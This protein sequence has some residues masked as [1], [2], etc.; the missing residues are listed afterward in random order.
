VIIVSLSLGS[1]VIIVIVRFFIFRKSRDHVIVRFFIFRKSRDHVIVSFIFCVVNLL[2]ESC[3]LLVSTSLV[4]NVLRESCDLLVS[5]SFV[6]SLK[7]RRFVGM[8]VFLTRFAALL[9]LGSLPVSFTADLRLAGTFPPEC[10]GD[11]SGR[12]TLLLGRWFLSEL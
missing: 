3:D 7:P 5:T 4:V 8:R 2:R 12:R 1:H 11:D 6:V 9:F 10:G